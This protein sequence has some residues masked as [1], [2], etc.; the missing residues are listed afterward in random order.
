LIF[1]SSGNKYGGPLAKEVTEE[2]FDIGAAV[3]LCS[4]AVDAVLFSPPYTI[5][6][7]E[8]KKLVSIFWCSV[9][10]VIVRRIQAQKI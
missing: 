10:L 7:A 9:E 3:Y 5:S 1:G 8:M 6:E 4:P 2:R